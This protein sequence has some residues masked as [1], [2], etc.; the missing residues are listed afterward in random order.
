M[1]DLENLLVVQEHDTRSDQLRHRRAALPER[2]A[3]AS[4]DKVIAD[5]DRE[6]SA[7]LAGRDGL[8][9]KQER[10]EVE[11]AADLR[12]SAELDRRLSQT[13]VPREAEAFQAEAKVVAAHRSHLEDDIYALMETIEPIDDRLK[14]IASQRA[15]LDERATVARAELAAAEVVID[16]EAAEVTAARRIAAE[17]VAE[18]LMARYERQRARLGGVAIARLEHGHCM[19]C[20]VEISRGELDAMLAR[21]PDALVECE[22]CGRMLVR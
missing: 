5:L 10:M 20:R 19:G 2:G 7:S 17:A 8:S 21:P 1:S 3:L 9:A 4:I 22:H 14:E 11:L 12:K 18:S 13:V 6:A 15:S 16:A